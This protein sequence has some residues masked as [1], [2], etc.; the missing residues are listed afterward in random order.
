MTSGVGWEQG[1]S[2]LYKSILGSF[3]LF[4]IRIWD[5]YL[6]DPMLFD[7]WQSFPTPPPLLKIGSASKFNGLS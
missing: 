2:W 3:C 7:F 6:G 1:K 5:D 4:L